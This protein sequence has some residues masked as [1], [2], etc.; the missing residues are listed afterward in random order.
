MTKIGQILFKSPCGDFHCGLR[1]F[2]KEAVEKIN[3]RTTGMEFASEMVV[4]A[5]LNNMKICEVPTTLS[6][7]GRTRTSHLNTWSDGWRHLRFMLMYS[8][9]W[10]FLY[11][12]LAMMFL[13][14]I[15]GLVILPGPMVIHGITFDL[16]TL[17]F[18]AMAV[19]LGFQSTTFA[20]VSKAFAVAERL[21]PPSRRLEFLFRYL[22]LEVGIVLG[23]C[24]ALP[25]LVGTIYTIII[26]GDASFGPLD[27][28]KTMRIAIPSLTVLTLG[29]QI[30]LFSFLFSILGLK[31]R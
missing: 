11:P 26:W 18:A 9:N 2:K 5:A 1:G 4:K 8:P 16:H 7:D 3:L 6:P 21:L 13:G 22:K 10:L 31:R 20:V 14:T 27:F 24:L 19:I 15:I 28:S 12:G 30:I 23:V 29:V 17:L 25:G